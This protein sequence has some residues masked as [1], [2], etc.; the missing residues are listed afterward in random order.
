MTEEP[1]AAQRPTLEAVAA[2]AGVS[3]ATVSR[4]V[5]GDPGV[6]E[7]LAGKVGTPSRNSATSPTTPP[8]ASSPAVTTRSP[9]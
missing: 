7:T 4:V 2:R 1:S 3:R 8:A 6:R 5:N 9:W